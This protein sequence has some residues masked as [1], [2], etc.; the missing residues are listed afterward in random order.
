MTNALSIYDGLRCF[1]PDQKG[2]QSCIM[3]TI[4][5]VFKLELN[6]G[7]IKYKSANYIE[8][9]FK[10]LLHLN[11]LKDFDKESEEHDLQLVIELCHILLDVEVTELLNPINHI[12]EYKTHFLLKGINLP[13]SQIAAKTGVILFKNAD[14]RVCINFGNNY[15]LTNAKKVDDRL[16]YC[17]ALEGSNIEE[18]MFAMAEALNVNV[19]KMIMPIQTTSDQIV[20]NDKF[21]KTYGKGIINDVKEDHVIISIRSIFT[22]EPVPG[23]VSLPVDFLEYD[24]K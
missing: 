18:M 5:D 1:I 17:T 6:N 15:G 14:R 21:F 7:T 22:G 20:F 2:N 9:E 24:N 12:T 10:I 4:L 8:E 23:Y 11:V 3:K 13:L 19:I 16:F